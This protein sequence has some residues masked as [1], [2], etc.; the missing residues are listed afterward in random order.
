MTTPLSTRNTY[1]R[2]CLCCAHDHADELDLLLAQGASINDVSRRFG[3]SGDSIRRHLNF[4]LKPALAA[5]IK[6]APEMRPASFVERVLAVANDAQRARR[7]AYQTGNSWLAARLG[8]SELKALGVL[9]DRLGISHDDA[10]NDLRDAASI[11]RVMGQL[12][13]SHPQLADVIAD[14]FGSDDRPDL[15]DEIR[16]QASKARVLT[17]PETSHPAGLEPSHGKTE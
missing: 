3:V 8:D 15:A 17:I 11:A 5:A 13:R 14:A 12:V 10:A 2:S 4:H 1:G 16:A 7:A 9:S 6:A